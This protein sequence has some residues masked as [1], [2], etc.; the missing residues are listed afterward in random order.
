MSAPCSIGRNRA[1]VAKVL[2]II[3]G[4]PASC[5]MRA[6]AA[7]SSTSR[8]GLPSVSAKTSRVS[9]RIAARKASRSR[10]GTK[11]VEMPKRGM[12]WAKRLCDPP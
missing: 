1:G 4:T 5:A 11:L 10:G 8:P 2:S 6:T 9:G 12:V 3:S 7:T